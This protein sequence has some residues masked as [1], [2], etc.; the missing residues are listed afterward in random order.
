MTLLLNLGF[1][2]TVALE[3]R[4]VDA[5]PE[6]LVNVWQLKHDDEVVFFEAAHDAELWDVVA[7]GAAAFKEFIVS[8]ET[9]NA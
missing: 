6:L 7:I 5:D 1:R 4:L 9:E 8:G 2:N 3:L